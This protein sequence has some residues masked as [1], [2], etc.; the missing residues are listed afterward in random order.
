LR[1]G[2]T[3]RSGYAT[4]CKTACFAFFISGHSEKSSKPG[5]NATN[6]L[7]R[8]SERATGDGGMV[9]A[10]PDEFDPEGRQRGVK[11]RAVSLNA[12][13]RPR[14]TERTGARSGGLSL[15]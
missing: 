12:A 1:R 4:V 8:V 6:R 14:G 11:A 3:W 10:P 15:I 7:G 5:L 2:A 9:S 13:A